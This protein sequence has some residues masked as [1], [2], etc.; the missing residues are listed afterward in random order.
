MKTHVVRLAFVILLPAVMSLPA[1]AQDPHDHHPT[2]TAVHRY[3]KRK[4]THAAHVTRV[5]GQRVRRWPHRKAHN[6]RAW[7]NKH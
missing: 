1:V 3:A 2:I 7:L 5:A 4:T 6:M